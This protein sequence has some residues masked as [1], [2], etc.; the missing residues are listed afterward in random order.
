MA[1]EYYQRQVADLVRDDG[2]RVTAEQI[3]AAVAA[4]VAQYS[5]QAPRSLTVEQTGAAG[6]FLA[7]PEGWVADESRLVSIEYPVGDMPP[8]YVPDGGAIVLPQPDGTETIGLIDGLPDP[9]T[10]RIRF[11]APHVVDSQADTVPQARRFGVALLAASIVCGQL[12]SFYANQ[13]DSTI[14]ADAVEHKSKSELWAARERAYAK[15]AEAALGIRL[16]APTA[17]AEAAGTVVSFAPR[18][19]NKFERGFR[20]F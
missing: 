14:A 2:D 6:Q 3:D 8:Q 7:T 11:T 9:S 1:I 5:G 18:R 19:G 10:V 4:A 20:I 12:A 17:T 16:A 13:T 15:Q